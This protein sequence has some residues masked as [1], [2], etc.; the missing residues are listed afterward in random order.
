[1]INKILQWL[2]KLKTDKLLHFIAGM[3]ISQVTY[4]L[5]SLTSLHIC[6][7]VLLSLTIT[8]ISGG[9][10]E[11]IDKKYGVP[12]IMDFVYTVIG[13]FIGVLLAMFISL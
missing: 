4:I 8:V 12:S 6:W 1:M 11:V 2:N 13:G 5:I 10:K 3:L 7:I 9:I